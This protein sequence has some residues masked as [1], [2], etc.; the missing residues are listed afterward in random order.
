MWRLGGILLLALSQEAGQPYANETH[1]FSIQPPAGW[2]RRPVG[3]PHEVKFVPPEELKT[4]CRLLVTH[5][6]TSNPTPLK[7]FVAQSKIFITREFKGA[8]VTDEKEL[9]IG[10]R[11][12]Y[13]QVYS[14]GEE[15]YVKTVIL[16]SNIEYYFVD[17]ILAQA[18]AAKYRP[19][20]EAAVDSFRIVPVKVKPEEAAALERTSAL[21][22][23]ARVIPALLGEQWYSVHLG[24]LRAGHQRVKVSEARG[25]YAFELD[26]KLDYG[27][28]GTDS[29]QVRGECSPDGSFQKV[30]FEQTK[31]KKDERWQF[32]AGALLQGGQAKVTRDMNGIK[33]EKTF[34]VE[35]GVVLGD[36]ADLLRR[37][38]VAAGKG[39][40]A[41][42]TLPIFADEPDLEMIEVNE[43]EPQE[44]DGKK[45]TASTVFCIVD[46]G[47]PQ[48]YSFS[49]EGTLLHHGSPK[50]LFSIR[51]STREE[52]LKP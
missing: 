13:R 50:D 31:T 20:A 37:A 2:L 12:A 6:H 52:A 44:V 10:G 16:R 4:P 33:E 40:Y 35:P 51:L 23:G 29:S 48:T 21:L 26:V 46:R 39:N 30:D 36:V 15:L 27:E 9:S 47:K 42:R 14:I 28:G 19:V 32:R 1:E 49:P 17:L 25:N 7:G 22:K 43:K 45:V 3:Q 8:V 24:K 18:D 11:P 5:F 38:L 41:L 34:A